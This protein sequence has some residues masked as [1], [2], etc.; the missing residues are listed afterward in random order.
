MRQ[1][2]TGTLGLKVLRVA[3]QRVAEV[4]QQHSIVKSILPRLGTGVHAL[5]MVVN[6][7]GIDDI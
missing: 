5:V 1:V 6:S 7:S 4:I 3:I 2:I